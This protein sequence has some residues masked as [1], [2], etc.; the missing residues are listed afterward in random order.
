MS[1]PTKKAKLELK[2]KLGDNNNQQLTAKD[3]RMECDFSLLIGGPKRG[4]S[5]LI[6]SMIIAGMLDGKWDHI[7]ILSPTKHNGDFGFIEPQSVIHGDPGKGG[8]NYAA[9]VEKLIEVQR[10]VSLKLG[11]VPR[12]GEGRVLLVIDDALG[13]INWNAAVWMKLVSTYRQFGI[14]VICST[15]AITRIP[16]NFYVTASMGY[17]FA[18]DM[19]TDVE[20]IWER[21]V[22]A[23]PTGLK[24]AKE[25]NDWMI[26]NMPISEHKFMK[27]NRN[28]DREN[29]VSLS[30][31]PPRS[32]FGHYRINLRPPVPAG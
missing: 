32:E 31:A 23:Y 2:Q 25:L 21:W 27:I 19:I 13:S 16:R 18:L 14:D 28:V 29:A 9:V 20:Y 3:D 24:N 17:V 6:A 10:Y 12:R 8:A 30:K 26:K 5:H 11:H 1:V 7:T 15:Q 22:A 4:K